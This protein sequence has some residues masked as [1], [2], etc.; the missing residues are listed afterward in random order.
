MRLYGKRFLRNR[1]QRA[2]DSHTE[3][4]EAMLWDVLADQRQCRCKIQGTTK[5]IIAWFPENWQTTPVWLKPG[6]AVRI[7]HVGG[8]RGRV[9][10]VGHG[11]R[12]PSPATGAVLPDPV[13]PG[14][15][16]VSG[17]YVTATAP[18][19]MDVDVSA[20]VVR[21]GGVEYVFSADT[22]TISTAPTTDQWRYDLIEVGADGTIDYTA[23][24]PSGYATE[25]T[26]P[27]V[28]TDHVLIA[29]VFVGNA[30]T[31]VPQSS[32][33]AFW[34]APTLSY[35]EVTSS[36]FDLAWGETDTDFTVTAKDQ[37]GHTLN[38]ASGNWQFRVKFI[39]GNGTL[40]GDGGTSTTEV[41]GS[42]A[43]SYTFNY[44]RDMNDP[45]DESPGFEV[46]VASEETPVY[47]WFGIAVYDTYGNKMPLWVDPYYT[48]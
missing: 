43:N 36:D 42:G 33:G 32:I 5:Y 38:R 1:Q 47:T 14:D 13:D 18:P 24:T 6:N 44:E 10:V 21:I 39:G 30:Q 34:T 35:L 3:T 48:S 41:Y 2:I 31:T 7:A 19:S 28:A 29:Y 4:R 37:Y 25:P 27:A 45:G 9:E 16:L 15:T 8:V 11:L 17:G 12:V 46:W 26:K 20:G 40:T 23:G 22:I